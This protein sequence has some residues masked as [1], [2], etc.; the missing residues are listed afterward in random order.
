MPTAGS[1][2]EGRVWESSRD[3]AGCRE[4]QAALESAGTDEE[5][6]ALAAELKG[7]VFEASRCP[8]ANHVLQKCVLTIRRESFQFIVD[9]V[10]AKLFAIAKSRFGCRVIQRLIERCESDEVGEIVS[11]L[12]AEFKDLSRHEYGNYVLQHILEHGTPEQQ[13][14][15]RSSIE[16]AAYDL[17]AHPQSCA[18]LCATLSGGS[19]E[20]QLVLAMRIM[21]TE[22]VELGHLAAMACKRRGHVVLKRALA[23]LG[24]PES[25][26]LVEMLE[27]TKS[28]LAVSKYGMSMLKFI[29]ELNS[30]VVDVQA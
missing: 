21:A 18:L 6:D 25:R 24:E 4:V 14:T 20:D 17:C 29:E 3:P 11:R 13:R 9:E 10:A 30:G 22:S 23:V 16:E 5:R 12:I 28:A 15:L 27:G 7:H 26:P 19:A 8:H 1:S 2:L